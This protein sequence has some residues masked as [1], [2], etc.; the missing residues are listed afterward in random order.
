[1]AEIEIFD[2]TDGIKRLKH[3]CGWRD[4]D[5]PPVRYHFAFEYNGLPRSVIVCYLA[6]P[7]VILPK[8][9]PETDPGLQLAITAA[10]E[11]HA[12]AFGA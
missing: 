9:V 4:K 3:H 1:M 5:L 10:K 2:N 11:K 8:G 6:K 12:K 7:F